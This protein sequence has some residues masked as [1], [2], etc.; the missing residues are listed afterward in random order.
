MPD[1]GEPN[2]SLQGFVDALNSGS[3]LQQVDAAE[4][5]AVWGIIRK[6]EAQRPGQQIAIGMD[7]ITASTPNHRV[8]SAA[9]AMA[10]MTRASLLSALLKRGALSEFESDGEPNEVVFRAA[11]TMPMGASDIGEV[12]MQMHS[13]KRSE[14]RPGF[15][16]KFM[17]T[18]RNEE[19]T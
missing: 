17:T 4:L 19:A 2:A 1:S 5:K 3:D 8:P 15:E 9:E 6:I 11:A 14:L 7:A 16:E 12:V 13:E 18:V 10:L